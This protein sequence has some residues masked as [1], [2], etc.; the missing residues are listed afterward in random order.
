MAA[1][2]VTG[3]VLN[4]KQVT[5]ADEGEGS[6]VRL[7][8]EVTP[9]DAA[10]PGLSWESS[11]TS[12]AKVSK[13]GYVKAVAAGTAIIRAKAVD[14]SG[15]SASC[16]VTVRERT[17][18]ITPDTL[19][20]SAGEKTSLNAEVIPAAA[21]T[22][23]SSAPE[24]AVVS[25]KGTVKANKAG[26]ASI[27]I[28]TAEGKC[29]EPVPVTVEKPRSGGNTVSAVFRTP[30]LAA[31]AG[32]M[33]RAG[34]AVTVTAD[35]PGGQWEVRGCLKLT[36]A[37]KDYCSVQGTAAGSGEV[38]YTLYGRSAAVCIVVTP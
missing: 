28:E 3:V 35:L 24:I 16:T 10:D 27:W 18:G 20:L 15:K 36:D 38:I 37:G 1:P 17:L 4:E 29:S 23:V 8:A 12:V 11:D 31:G 9:S 21:V 7:A 33:I 26:T 30:K 14:G 5:L 2:T 13:N 6:S 25:Q 22:W 19:L 34:T 32:G